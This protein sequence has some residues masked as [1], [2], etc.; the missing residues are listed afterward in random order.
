M[1]LKFKQIICFRRDLVKNV[2]ISFC[3]KD[4]YFVDLLIA[5][6][7]HHR[8]NTWCS[9]KDIPPGSEFRIYID[10]G[11]KDAEAMIVVVTQNAVSSK[12]M[13]KELATYQERNRDGKIIPLLLDHTKP[14]LVLDRLSD[15]QYINFADNYLNGFESLIKCFNKE[16]LAIEEKRKSA[17][18]RENERRAI[19]ERR[20]APMA[21]RFRKGFWKA[22]ANKLSDS[23]FEEIPISVHSMHKIIDI[24]ENEAGKY[25]Y[26]DIN[27]EINNSRQVLEKALDFLL[28]E[29]RMHGMMKAIYIVEA[30][31]EYLCQN[32][33]PQLK[34]ERRVTQDKRK[35]ETR[36]C[37]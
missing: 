20:S 21:Q 17:D 26:V 27:G 29:W 18:R 4:A 8:I 9:M 36:R 23:K 31:A 32:Y 1:G 5:I 19:G 16:F 13:T 6:L 33:K 35:I 14:D 34:N 22:Y 37:E 3:E 11:L 24:L 12:W 25:N 15:Y 7:E 2:F 28:E 30:F 10:K